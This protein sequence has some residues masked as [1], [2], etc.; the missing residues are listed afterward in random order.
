MSIDSMVRVAR[1]LQ[2]SMDL[3]NPSAWIDGFKYAD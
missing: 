2:T 3:L 1:D